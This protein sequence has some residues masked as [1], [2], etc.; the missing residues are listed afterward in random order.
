MSDAVLIP[1]GVKRRPTAHTAPLAHTPIRV[2]TRVLIARDETRHPSKGSWPQFRG[3]TGT[4]IEINR[5]GGGATEYGIGFGKTVR[6]DVWFL[7]H[8]LV[9]Q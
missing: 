1:T 4:V 7:A 3:K 2:G 5:A 6:T 9:A 8:E